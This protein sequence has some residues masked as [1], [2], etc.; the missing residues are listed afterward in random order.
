MRNRWYKLF[1]IVCGLI[2]ITVPLFGIV[3]CA[4]KKPPATVVEK[5]TE[6][7]EMRKAEEA[8]DRK[9]VV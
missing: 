5:I 3:S 9:S 2:L 6:D 1:V 7:E 8:R 4:K